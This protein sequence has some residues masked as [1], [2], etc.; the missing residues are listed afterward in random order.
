MNLMQNFYVV[1][2][3]PRIM[4]QHKTKSSYNCSVHQ[5][6]DISFVSQDQARKGSRFQGTLQELEVDNACWLILKSKYI[7]VLKSYTS[8]ETIMLPVASH[9]ID[10]H[11]ILH[12]LT[13]DSS[14]DFTFNREYSCLFQA[15]FDSL[16]TS[17]SPSGDI[18]CHTSV[19]TTGHYR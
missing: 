4:N 5:S 14:H 1:N 12:S 17:Q 11:M 6:S 13:M 10:S 19:S 7:I 3:K 16:T 8:S 18:P 15:T 2:D 9:L